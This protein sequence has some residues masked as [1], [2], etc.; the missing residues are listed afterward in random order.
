MEI[1]YRVVAF[2]FL[3]PLGACQAL[4]QFAIDDECR[5]AICQA[6]AVGTLVQV[7]LG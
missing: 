7:L 2:F 4:A 1:S 3:T 5:E 6:G